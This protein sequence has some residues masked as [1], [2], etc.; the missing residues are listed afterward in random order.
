MRE[1][2]R[3]ESKIE[4][5]RKIV[6]GDESG[7]QFAA[8]TVLLLTNREYAGQNLHRCLPGNEPQAFAQFD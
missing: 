7:E 3:R 5:R 2:P 6:A 1:R 8:R 4:T